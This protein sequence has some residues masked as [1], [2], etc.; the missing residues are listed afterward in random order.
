[1]AEAALEAEILGKVRPP[2]AVSHPARLSQ[3][4]TDVG[5]TA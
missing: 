3:A 1:M 4:A 2:F 5:R